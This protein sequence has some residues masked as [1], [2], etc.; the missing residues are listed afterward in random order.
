MLEQ[1]FQNIT[2]HPQLVLVV[3]ALMIIGYAL[4]RTPFVKDWMIIWIL[5]GC[6]I[7]AS[8]M[9]LGFDVN[10]ISN[11]ILAAGAAITTHQAIK[12]SIKRNK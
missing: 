8:G 11:G 9:R 6:G 5:L 1:L 3:P 2:I 12:Q 4:K 7:I 10:G